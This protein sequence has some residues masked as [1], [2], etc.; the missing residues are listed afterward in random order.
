MQFVLAAG[1]SIAASG[2]HAMPMSYAMPESGAVFGA[3]D[4]QNDGCVGM[5]APLHDADCATRCLFSGAFLAGETPVLQ[6][7][8]AAVCAACV[9][10]AVS[11]LRIRAIV[12]HTNAPP[13]RYALSLVRVST[14]RP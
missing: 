3:T 12:P 5:P 1:F 2:A 10:I 4:C 14:L 8:V 6:A 13:Q 7:V 9:V 11:S